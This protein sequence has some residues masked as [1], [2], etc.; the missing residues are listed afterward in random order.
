[1]RN[2]ECQGSFKRVSIKCPEIAKEMSLKCRRR[3]ED[4]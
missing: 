3:A 2:F 1:M 4:V